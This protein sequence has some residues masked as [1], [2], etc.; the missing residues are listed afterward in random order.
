MVVEAKIMD[1]QPYSMPVFRHAGIYLGIVAVLQQPGSGF[2]TNEFAKSWRGDA[3]E[4]KDPADPIHFCQL[5][6]THGT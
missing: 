2:L 4:R 5:C 1:K 3:T 6:E